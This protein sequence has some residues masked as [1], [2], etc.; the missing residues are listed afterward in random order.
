MNWKRQKNIIWIICYVKSKGVINV[1]GLYGFL[2]F[3]ENTPKNLK[4]IYQRNLGKEHF[5]YSIKYGL[6]NE[7]DKNSWGEIR[8]GLTS[9]GIMLIKSKD[10]NECL[11]QIV[12]EESQ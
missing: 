7:F 9:K 3:L 8:Y 11:R 6:I 5:E 2:T 12:Q 10:F 4:I 1:E